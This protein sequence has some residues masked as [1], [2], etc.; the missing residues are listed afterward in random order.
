MEQVEVKGKLLATDI[1][2]RW[3]R[4]HT[5]CDLMLSAV[6]SGFDQGKYD[7]LKA[8]VVALRGQHKEAQQVRAKQKEVRAC[9]V[10]LAMSATVSSS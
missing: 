5:G 7:S 8:S 10:W 4:L 2:C 9:G 1:G 6:I 3:L